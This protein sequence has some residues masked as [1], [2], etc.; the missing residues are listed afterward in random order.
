LSWKAGWQLILVPAATFTLD[1][2]LQPGSPLQPRKLESA[3]GRASSLTTVPVGKNAL[4]APVPLPPVMVQSIPAGWEV[5]RPFPFPPG[6]I[7]MLPFAAAKAVCTVMVEDLVMPPADAMIVDDWLLLTLLVDT[8]KVALVD[9]A[10]TVTLAGTVAAAVLLEDNE[11]AR[12]PDGA[13]EV[14]VMVPVAELPPTTV[15]GLRLSAESDA[16]DGV[17]TV[18]PD[19]LAEATVA[20]PSFTF[21]M[22]SSG[23]ANGSLSILKAPLLSLVPM[24]T[25]LT[26]IVVFA[27][28]W[29][30]IRSFVPLSSA[31]EM[32]TVACAVETAT[33]RTSNPTAATATANLRKR[34]GDRSR[35]SIPLSPLLPKPR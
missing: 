23:F 8:V 2:S 13:A 9:P 30:S 25:P 12:P 21:T 20:E 32:L 33:I 28:A 24:A 29:P 16:V 18:Q 14:R 3:A 4:Q 34:R 35:L 15:V 19:S 26:V 27:A 7:E 5:I 1:G 11:T 31:R 10:G 22:Q 17:L 6:M